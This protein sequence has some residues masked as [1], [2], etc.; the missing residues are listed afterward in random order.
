M[1]FSSLEIP[2]SCYLDKSNNTRRDLR[3]ARCSWKRCQLKTVSVET[4]YCNSSRSCNCSF[5]CSATFFQPPPS[6]SPWVMYSCS[7]QTC[8][9][10]IL[11]NLYCTNMCNRLHRSRWYLPCIPASLLCATARRVLARCSLASPSSSDVHPPAPLSLVQW[12]RRSRQEF[13][14]R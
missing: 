12:C 4:C 10:P 11:I 7:L 14:L 3:N 6:R 1:K 8:I 5:H 2:W 13:F 9:T